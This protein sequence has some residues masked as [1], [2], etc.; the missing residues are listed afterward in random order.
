M[1]MRG[2]PTLNIKNYAFHITHFELHLAEIKDKTKK[3]IVRVHHALPSFHEEMLSARISPIRPDRI[4][5]AGDTVCGE[6][7]RGYLTDER[8]SSIP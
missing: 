2:S 4:S 6:G 1:K 8:T 7:F 3:L 5:L